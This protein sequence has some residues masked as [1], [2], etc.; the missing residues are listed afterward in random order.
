[1][2]ERIFGTLCL[3]IGG[4]LATA[5]LAIMFD[6]GEAGIPVFLSMFFIGTGVIV[7]R[8]IEGPIYGEGLAKTVMSTGLL[9]GAALMAALFL[10]VLFDVGFDQPSDAVIP[11]SLTL[12]LGG[13]G[14]ALRGTTASGSFTTDLTLLGVGVVVVPLL[15]LLLVFAFANSSDNLSEPPEPPEPAEPSEPEEPLDDRPVVITNDEGVPAGVLGATVLLMMGGTGA[16]LFWSRRAVAPMAEITA[17]ANDIQA[18]SLDRRI[19]LH[20]GTREV[21]Q[22]ADSFDQMLDRLAQASSTQQRMIEDASHELRTP[23]AALAINNEVAL[24]ASEP[25]LDGYRQAIERNQALVERLQ[26]TIDE[27]L[28]EGRAERQQLQQVDNDLLAIV[29]RVAD[30][31]RVTSPDVPIVVRGPASLRLGID[32]PSVQRAIENLVQNAARY[33]PPGVPVEIDVTPT[34]NVTLLSVT[35]HGPGIPSDK[36]DAIFERYYQGDPE[37]GGA[38][39]IGL[40]VVKQVAEAH[41]GIEVLSPVSEDGGTRF[42]LTFVG[43]NGQVESAPRDDEQ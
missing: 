21:Q 32:G 41:G 1:M 43:Q 42:T 2:A 11:L 39:G 27:L 22:L 28:A 10:A 24:D 17:V 4:L 3:V 34:A 20:G 40:S 23:L 13:S 38:A 36:V 26:L 14:L 25:T 6:S 12:L 9:V 29:A 31:H 8:R 15:L 18:G 33:S 37:D 5:S 30:Q 35:D 16:V 19:G 7:L